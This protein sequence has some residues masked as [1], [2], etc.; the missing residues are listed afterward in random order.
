[1]CAK[2][3][4]LFVDDEPYV[5]SGL[6]RMLRDQ[7][8]V[9][10][11][12]FVNCGIAALEKFAE[13]PY[14]VIVTDMRMPGMDGAELL[15]HVARDYPQTVRLVLSGQSKQERIFRAI[16]PAHQFLSKPC[17]EQMLVRTVERACGV[18]SRLQNKSLQK[19]VSRIGVLPSLPQ[20]YRRLVEELESADASVDRV[21]EIIESDLAMSAKVLQLTNSSFFGLPHHVTCPRHAVSMLGLSTVRA[22]GLSAGAFAQ[23][24]PS[25]AGFSLEAA[26]QHGLAVATAARRIAESEGTD[27]NLVDD[28]FIAGLLHDIGQLILATH[29]SRTYEEC[30]QLSRA[31]KLPLWKAEL[32]V[33]GTT[34]GEIGA[35]LLELWGLPTP[36][37][38]AVALHHRP[39]QAVGSQFTPLTA[40]HV[41]DCLQNGHANSHPHVVMDEQSVASTDPGELSQAELADHDLDL[42]YLSMLHLDRRLESWR[43][44]SNPPPITFNFTA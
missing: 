26:V 34:H 6:R 16:G 32:E 1:M 10:E 11:M 35:H 17:D 18:C 23:F 42:A 36:I 8:R 25:A 13:Q 5:L 9:W 3:R 22:L 14:D 24:E 41:A 40:V 28:S 21:G 37:V 29:L 12:D 4:V 30:L 33:V 19:I 43:Q 27:S 39:G 2:P 38:E 15:T 20:L 44:L 7:R 31:E